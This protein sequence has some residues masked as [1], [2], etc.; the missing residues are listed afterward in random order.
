M[1]MIQICHTLTLSR[2]LTII[3]Y[4]D[5]CLDRP[6]NIR[7]GNRSKKL[8][9]QFIYFLSIE[10][11]LFI[12]KSTLPCVYIT[13]LSQYYVVF[14]YNVAGIKTGR[15]TYEKRTS[16]IL[17]LKRLHGEEARQRVQD[18]QEQ[19]THR[20]EQ[21]IAQIVAAQERNHTD[22]SQ[23]NPIINEIHKS[24]LVSTSFINFSF[25]LSDDP[26]VIS[27]GCIVQ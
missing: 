4:V 2:L 3:E 6:I 27:S 13:G 25:F 16:D 14:P 5:S 12:T 15:Y 22:A 26:T 10:Y 24:Y 19:L 21:L 7:R 20:F 9:F 1:T 8:Q 11:K 23:T 18:R 17:E